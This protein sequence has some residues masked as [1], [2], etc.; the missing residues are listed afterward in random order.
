MKKENCDIVFFGLKTG[1][2]EYKNGSIN[3]FILIYKAR[4]QKEYI[5]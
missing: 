1:K 2:S 3:A 4:K 5:K